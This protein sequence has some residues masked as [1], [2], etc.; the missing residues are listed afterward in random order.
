M[1]LPRAPYIY[2][3][4]WSLPPRGCERARKG[5]K[6]QHRWLVRRKALKSREAG[7]QKYLTKGMLEIHTA[8]STHVKEW[9]SS[10]YY[11]TNS[12]RHQWK[13]QGGSDK[14][15]GK[16]HLF[17]WHVI[18]PWDPSHRIWWSQK[19]K[20]TLKHNQGGQDRG[21][22]KPWTTQF[23]SYQTHIFSSKTPSYMNLGNQENKDLFIHA[24]LFILPLSRHPTT[25]APAREDVCSS[26]QYNSSPGYCSQSP[27]H[28][29]GAGLVPQAPESRLLAPSTTTWGVWV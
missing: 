1:I 28:P 19:Y 29:A 4:L 22:W 10:R 7:Q 17:L 8:I 14:T 15:G 25:S 11:C 24:M 13:P 12:R 5:P 9:L 21:P 3:K 18:K 26:T 2:T 27:G 16:Q 20:Q 6:Q 23:T